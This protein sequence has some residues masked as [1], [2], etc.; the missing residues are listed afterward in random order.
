MSTFLQKINEAAGQFFEIVK[1]DPIYT[2]TFVCILEGF[3]ILGLI[4]DWDWTLATNRYTVSSF[5]YWLLKLPR[6]TQR[7]VLGCLS[8]LVVIL[9]G[10]LLFWGGA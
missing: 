8:V 4:L 10:F 6:K 5:Q 2:F 1:S 9:F 3:Y 7:I